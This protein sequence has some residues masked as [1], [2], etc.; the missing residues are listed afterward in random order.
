[1]LC[2]NSLLIHFYQNVYANGRFGCQTLP[3]SM[4]LTLYG[5]VYSV[6]C[7]RSARSHQYIGRLTCFYWYAKVGSTFKSSCASN[8]WHIKKVN[9]KLADH[10][11]MFIFIRFDYILRKPVHVLKLNSLKLHV[12]TTRK[13]VPCQK[14]FVSLSVSVIFCSDLFL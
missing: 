7:S 6:I 12:L 8:N 1:M 10:T 3:L 4:I 9:V 13:S 5:T 14:L 11:F 2:H